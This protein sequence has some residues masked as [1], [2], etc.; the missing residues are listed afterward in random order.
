MFLVLIVE[1]R[2][3]AGTG[4]KEMLKRYV[5]RTAYLICDNVTKKAQC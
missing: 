4:A 1:C 3:S 5:Q 2:D